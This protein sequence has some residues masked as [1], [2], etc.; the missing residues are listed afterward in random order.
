MRFVCETRVYCV[1]QCQLYW[2]RVHTQG[3]WENVLLRRPLYFL[4]QKLLQAVLELLCSHLAYRLH[5]FQ[6]SFLMYNPTAKL[7]NACFGQM[8]P[9][10]IYHSFHLLYLT[11]S[12]F[13]SQEILLKKKKTKTKSQLCPAGKSKDGLCHPHDSFP[14]RYTHIHLLNILFK[15][16]P[17]ERQWT[18]MANDQKTTSIIPTMRV[19]IWLPGNGVKQNHEVPLWRSV[20]A[21]TGKAAFFLRGYTQLLWNTH[22]FL[23]TN[24]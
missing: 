9:H 21:E 24:M 2:G 19:C 23:V 22:P 18:S 20:G 6:F 5:F 13:K 17:V 12:S 11:A 16:R 7:L 4:P 15:R 14:S 1:P 8:L 3:P 10:A